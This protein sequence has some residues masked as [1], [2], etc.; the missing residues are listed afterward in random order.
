MGRR[1]R[2][3]SSGIP[4]SL[5]SPP[6]PRD[7]DRTPP[8]PFHFLASIY[9][10]GRRKAE[11]KIIVYLDP[12][13]EDFNR[14]DGKVQFKTRWVEGRDGKLREHGWMFK[15]V[16]IETVFDK[17]LL[18]GDRRTSRKVSIRDE[19]SI[20]AAMNATD[21]GAEGDV[22]REE[23]TK[24]GQ[25]VITFE[26]VKLGEKW[27]DD[28][29]QAKHKEGEAD[30]VDMGGASSG[31]TH[32]AGLVNKY[33]VVREMLT[34]VWRFEQAKALRGDSIRVVAYTH[35]REGEGIYATFQF[36]YRSEGTK[37]SPMDASRKDQ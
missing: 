3:E 24:L 25:I 21:L 23:K 19:D 8:P 1:S 33:V 15:D 14:P 10:D 6:R 11:R 37:I 13:D 31:I 16:G 20:I 32:T 22:E 26:R 34:A 4:L 18:S 5:S 12:D 28:R 30:D 7:F 36:F 2:R 29:Y 27:V 9:L 17:M 35:Y